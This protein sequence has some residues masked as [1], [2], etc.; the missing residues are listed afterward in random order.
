[1]VNSVSEPRTGGKLS[2]GRSFLLFLLCVPFSILHYVFGSRP[3]TNGVGTDCTTS[4]YQS[5][6]RGV[7]LY[8]GCTEQLP[9]GTNQLRAF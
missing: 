2:I 6:G 1:M 5:L 3:G 9:N 4:E 8:A 7:S